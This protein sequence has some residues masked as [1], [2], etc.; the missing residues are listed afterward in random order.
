MFV[1]TVWSQQV[2]SLKLTLTYY[3]VSLQARPLHRLLCTAM[4]LLMPNLT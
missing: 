1:E 4:L 2:S 3:E